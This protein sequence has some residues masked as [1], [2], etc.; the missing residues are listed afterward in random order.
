[1]LWWPWSVT[2]PPA[3]RSLHQRWGCEVE[4][5]E[6]TGARVV[7]RGEVGAQRDL[8][9]VDRSIRDG[10]VKW[11]SG[12]ERLSV[13]SKPHAEFGASRIDQ[14]RRLPT[15]SLRRCVLARSRA[16]ARLSAVAALCASRRRRCC[17]AD[18][19]P[20]L[21]LDPPSLSLVYVLVVV[22][23]RAGESCARLLPSCA[24]RAAALYHSL[25]RYRQRDS[26]W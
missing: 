22:R 17:A 10:V 21:L 3:G 1:M 6:A 9:Q 16:G 5:P 14:F 2:R 8:L 23:L 24:W 13:W 19:R 12:R 25:V 4:P 18:A 11:S 7:G 15:T 20:L 26:V